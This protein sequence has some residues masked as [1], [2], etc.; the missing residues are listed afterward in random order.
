MMTTGEPKGRDRKQKTTGA[1]NGPPQGAIKFSYNALDSK[2]AD[3]HHC[4][5]ILC[6]PFSLALFNHH[7]SF[8]PSSSPKPPPSSHPCSILGG[9]VRFFIH[10]IPIPW[11]NWIANVWVCVRSHSLRYSGLISPETHKRA[12][13]PMAWTQPKYKMIGS[14]LGLAFQWHALLFFDPFFC[15]QFEM[16]L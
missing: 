13:C 2:R 3:G 9:S 1:P 14:A 16:P 15:W 6:V 11:P 4:L 12:F 7:I 10:S 5:L 8:P